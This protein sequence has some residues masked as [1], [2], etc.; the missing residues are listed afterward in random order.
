MQ[1]GAKRS[2]NDEA[3][4]RNAGRPRQI[5]ARRSR[6]GVSHDGRARR[7]PDPASFLDGK[8]SWRNIGPNI[9]GR[10][11]AVTGVPSERNLFY[12]G[13]VDGGVWKS[14]DY[15]VALAQHHRRQIALGERQHRRH[16]GRAFR[17][18]R[19]ST[20]GTGETDI[21]NDMITGDGVFSSVDA[22]QDLELCGPAEHTHDQRD[23]GRSARPERRLRR[24]DGTRVHAECRARRLQIHRRRQDLAARSS[25][26][27]TRPAPSTS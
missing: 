26:S 7:D 16:R 15:G 22:R 24:I 21:R 5:S 14:T 23:R 12:M 8:L 3:T 1:S 10:V 25:S 20:S 19:C 11:V 2:F 17:C 27:T 4:C 9:G 6:G 18:Q 13:G